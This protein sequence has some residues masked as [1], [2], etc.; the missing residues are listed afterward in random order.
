[1]ESHDT[2]IFPTGVGVNRILC[3][4]RYCGLYIPHRRGGEPIIDID[5]PPPGEYSPQAWG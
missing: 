5:H 3:N 4:H 1:M 2:A